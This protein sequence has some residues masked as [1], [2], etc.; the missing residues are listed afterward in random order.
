L[1]A[2]D[3]LIYNNIIIDDT[4]GGI[5]ANQPNSGNKVYNNSIYSHDSSVPRYGVYIQDAANAVDVKNNI[6][7]L[8]NNSTS[9]YNLYVAGGSAYPT[10]AYNNWYNNNNANRVYWKGTVFTSTQQSD[11]RNAGHPG[12]LFADPQFV[13]PTAGDFYLQFSSIAIDAG[14][15][16]G[17]TQDFYGRP[18]PQ[19]SAPDI[20]A[21]EYYSPGELADLN[22]DGEVDLEDFAVFAL[23]WMN[24]NVYSAFDWCQGTDFDMSGTVD[25]SDLTYFVENW[26][27]QA[28]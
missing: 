6:I 22:D 20:G 4:Y 21:Y 11:W 7:Y 10:V 8:S 15:D 27:R 1:S 18:V 23:Y 14:I 5:Y 12:E 9:T 3:T 28:D 17:L 25:M 2:T 13:N 26:L 24:E 19:G 16:V